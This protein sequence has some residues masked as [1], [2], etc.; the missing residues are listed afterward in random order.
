MINLNRTLNGVNARVLSVFTE[1]K[2]RISRVKLVD[3]VCIVA[4]LYKMYVRINQTYEYLN[5][6][7]AEII[8]I[9]KLINDS[10]N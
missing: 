8:E 6:H 4:R 5:N 1:V 3:V 10:L 7:H 9:I 2:N